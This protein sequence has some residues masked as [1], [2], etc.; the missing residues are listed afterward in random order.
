MGRS[1]KRVEI[2]DLTQQSPSGWGAEELS[3]FVQDQ[4]REVNSV[5]VILNTKMA[6]RKLFE[7]LNEVEWYAR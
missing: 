4:M 7:T 2:H 5:L 3:S 6:V 1:F